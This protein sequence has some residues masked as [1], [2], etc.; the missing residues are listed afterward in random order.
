D[1]IRVRLPQ[2]SLRD[3]FTFTANASGIN[4]TYDT[5]FTDRTVPSI[6][7]NGTLEQVLNNLLT[8]N[9][10]FYSIQDEHTIIVAQD[11]APNR[12]RYERQVI[13]TIPVSYA[14]ATE[15]ATMLNQVTRT[16]T[17]P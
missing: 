7:V 16:T 15:L 1:H 17:S 10:L 14:D 12:L 9:G 11:T 6:D 3:I 13:I 2:A 4:I 5:S 8:S